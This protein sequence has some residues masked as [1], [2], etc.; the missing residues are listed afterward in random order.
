MHTVIDR[1]QLTPID[2]LDVASSRLI[3]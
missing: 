3:D 2:P 1:Y